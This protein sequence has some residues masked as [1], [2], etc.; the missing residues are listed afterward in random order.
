MILREYK[1]LI[2]QDI[3]YS[4]EKN[5]KI[6]DEDLKRF[7]E[8]KMIKIPELKNQSQT[9]A[10]KIA[11][12]VDSGM[13]NLEHCMWL[14][15]AKIGTPKLHYN[16]IDR[17]NWGDF[18]SYDGD[19]NILVF[20]YK[21]I[22]NIRKKNALNDTSYNNSVWVI[23]FDKENEN[24]MAGFYEV[25]REFIFEEYI[26]L[27]IDIRITEIN[28]KERNRLQQIHEELLSTSLKINN[29]GTTD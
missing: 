27:L 14:C 23:T 21:V 1:M 6:S 16:H 18:A 3:G 20:D 11:K 8:S 13:G 15:D 19:Y 5:L 9:L 28:S 26:N 7:Y 10:H 25:F 17:F 29:H 24:S 12:L 22:I 4:F 2:Y